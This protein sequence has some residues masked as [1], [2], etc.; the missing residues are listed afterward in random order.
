MDGT[1]VTLKLDL[2]SR[3][4]QNELQRIAEKAAEKFTVTL[5]VK[6]DQF[7]KVL[8]EFKTAIG[9][10]NNQQILLAIDDEK[11]RNQMKSLKTQ[12]SRD[13]DAIKADLTSKLK[14]LTSEKA[15]S[16]LMKDILGTDEFSSDEKELKKQ[17]DEMMKYVNKTVNDLGTI[18]PVKLF[19]D[20]ALDMSGYDNQIAA[21]EKIFQIKRKMEQASKSLGS[22]FFSSIWNVNDADLSGLKSMLEGNAVKDY[23]ASLNK[24]LTDIEKRMASQKAQLMS[25]LS[26]DR[27]A[28]SSGT[29]DAYYETLLEQERKNI[30]AY[31]K[32]MES[33]IKK[34]SKYKE[35]LGNVTEETLTSAYEAFLAD[36]DLSDESYSEFLTQMSAFIKQYEALGHSL[37]DTDIFKEMFKDYSNAVTTG[38]KLLAPI[39]KGFEAAQRLAELESLMAGSQERLRGYLTESA[40]G[41]EQQ[42]LEIDFDATYI[43]NRLEAIIQSVSASPEI[44]FEG[45]AIQSS[46]KAIIE[47]T[48]ASPDVVPGEELGTRIQEAIR[49]VSASPDFSELK[50]TLDT[51]LSNVKVKPEIDYGSTSRE[52][53]FDGSSFEQRLS[54]FEKFRSMIKEYESMLTKL[55]DFE[56]KGYNLPTANNQQQTWYSNLVAKIAEAE[57]EL[58][59][60]KATYESVTL[61]MRDGSTEIIPVSDL[62][63]SLHHYKQIQ[64]VVFNLKQYANQGMTLDVD[65]EKIKNSIQGV[66]ASPE[67]VINEDELKSKITAIVQSI[68][69]SPD[70]IVK[71]DE[72]KS[73]IV[74]IIQS[75]QALPEIVVNEDELKSRIASIIQ[76]VQAAPEVLTNEEE[77]RSRLSTI[78]Q[79]VHASPTVSINEDELRARLTAIIQSVQAS[80]TITI[81]G[82]ALKQDIISA[83]NGVQATPEI[84]VGEELAEQIR[85]A[86]QSV[87]TSPSFSKTEEELSSAIKRGSS[88]VVSVDVN[89]EKIQESISNAV[90]GKVYMAAI[91]ADPDILS[92]SI[93]AILDQGYKI[94]IVPSVESKQVGKLDSYA[95]AIEKINNQ[96]ELK[97]NLTVEGFELTTEAFAEEIK[98]AK[99]LATELKPLVDILQRIT[100][101]TESSDSKKGNGS[102]K[103]SAN[104]NS[105]ARKGTSLAKLVENI[106]R[107]WKTLQ[108]TELLDRSSLN[109]IETEVIKIIGMA[110]KLKDDP[111]YIQKMSKNVKQLLR[112]ELERINEI[113]MQ[114]GENAN[115]AYIKGKKNIK[116]ISSLNGNAD[117][118]DSA[119]IGEANRLAAGRKNASIKRRASG[120]DV[121]FLNEQTN[122]VEKYRLSLDSTGKAI[123][124]NKVSEEEYI[125]TGKKLITSFKNKILQITQYVS[126][127]NL[128]YKALDKVKEGIKVVREMDAA[129]TEL[130]KVTD[131]ASITY[132]NFPKVASDIAKEVGSTSKEIVNATADWARMGY[133]LKEAQELAKT[134]AMYVNV[135]DGISMDTA[136]E[137][138]ISTLQG[139]QLKADDSLSIVDKFNEVANKF[140]IDS[141]GIGQALQRSAASFNAANTDLSSSIA[142]ITATNEIVQDP[143][144]VGNM[145]KTVSARI[146]GAETELTEAG[147]ETDGMVEST[148]KL[149]DI[150][151]SM[152]GFDIMYDE[153]TFKNMKDIIVGIGKEWNNLSDIDQAALLEKLAGKAQANSLAAALSNWETIE[154]A[155]EVAENSAGSAT[156]ENEKYLDSLEGHAITLEESFNELWNSSI[157]T[158]FLKFIIDV[159]N[160]L[161]TIVNNVGVLQTALIGLY[162]VLASKFNI[163]KTECLCRCRV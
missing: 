70:I 135:G 93:N 36:P 7:Q 149:R 137:S 154:K 87:E 72:L 26:S 46:L 37:P 85:T 42:K 9:D 32:E 155:Y 21:I 103:K 80:P 146:R 147:L 48:Q 97:N 141:N 29:T 124:L 156:A 40:L 100:K 88:E 17:L 69:A 115:K 122:M 73:K 105:D 92:K 111:L 101:K 127:I 43:Q 150:V 145:W 130:K 59:L 22:D 6:D 33:L 142:L 23:F 41:T 152:T 153:S 39:T 56:S 47:G 2:D 18:K 114:A 112:P 138:L 15:T 3:E 74:S 119:M 71:E 129:M 108:N 8:Q 24:E 44:T 121:S 68:Q 82:E 107:Q 60:F 131:E 1:R 27:I 38:D 151:K 63:E 77:L 79:S 157:S 20:D 78:I 75:I 118:I 161:L 31:E 55:N 11:V 30:S 16:S 110:E 13:A 51:L 49:A 66:Q 159:G 120:Y 61:T 67:I 117:A 90:M 133:S 83:A 53:F 144:K 148:S 19:G 58:S 50:T 140:A 126:G 132:K 134:S 57:R 160:G 86:I 116:D 12:L 4:A 123:L 113:L 91:N 99:E 5:G 14:G 162:T 34:A 10:L 143:E 106:A 96:L 128:I 95:Y 76:S 62:Q 163:G 65:A 81:N 89:S 45:E 102:S 158:E 125:S 84:V 25:V 109:G 94:P 139:F 104:N 35:L 28:G 64:D 98:L 54:S 52:D 136:N